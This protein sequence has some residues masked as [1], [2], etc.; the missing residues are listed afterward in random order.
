MT[1]GWGGGLRRS[2][3]VEVGACVRRLR[4]KRHFFK[5][6]WAA[7]LVDYGVAQNDGVADVVHLGGY[8]QRLADSEAEVSA[9]WARW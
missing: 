5:E 3:V 7:A 8:R 1:R 6:K 4:H 9:G 2:H